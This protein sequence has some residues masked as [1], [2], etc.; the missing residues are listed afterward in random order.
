VKGW[1]RW[2]IASALALTLMF[3]ADVWSQESNPTTATAP[4]APA[5]KAKDPMHPLVKME[6]TLGDIVLEL[7]AEKAPI[8]TLNFIDYANSGYYVG[9]IFHRVVRKGIYVI[10]GGGLTAQMDSK[11][12]ARAPIKNE[13]LNG[14]KNTTGTITMARLP[15]PDTATSQFFI[16]VQANPALDAA[17]DR[18]GY[19]VF[20]RVIEGMST[21][22][23]IYNTP[24]TAHPKY[25]GGAVV[26]QTPV[27]ITAVKTLDA[28]DRAALETR[29]REALEKIELATADRATLQRKKV[30]KMVARAEQQ[31]GKKAQK[32]ASGLI[33]L[34]ERDGAGPKP[35][36]TDKVEVH[37]S[38]TLVDGTEFDSS[39][40]RGAPSSFQLNQVIPGWTEGL[41]L[42]PAGAKA[43]LFIPP[44]LGYGETGFGQDIPPNS[45]LIFEIELLAIK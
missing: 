39:Y 3:C 14:L 30:E 44:D 26:P 20:G 35:K 42:M 45:W 9:T 8:T 1:N 7:D 37:Y 16:N 41:G 2:R 34:I 5:L 10:Q 21:V 32:T 25:P 11:P 18:P 33:I 36:P 38:G 31:T 13:G 12:G 27:V 15:M 40:K 23:K 29:A 6:T 22:E 4:T 43:K 19:A 17:P 24:L 28:I